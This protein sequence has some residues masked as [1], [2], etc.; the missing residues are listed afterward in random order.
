MY[1][2]IYT[3]SET[4]LVLIQRKVNPVK[5]MIA[6]VTK[7]VTASRIFYC[8]RQRHFFW[9]ENLNAFWKSGFKPMKVREHPG[10]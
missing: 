5:I 3:V 4:L 2:L 9:E 1:Q 10:I 7:N 6:N 8:L